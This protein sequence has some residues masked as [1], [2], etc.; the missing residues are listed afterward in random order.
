MK[1]FINNRFTLW[2]LLSI[3]IAF[4]LSSC[5]KFLE[6]PVDGRTAISII[7]DMEK[8]LNSIHP[9][10]DH[11]FTD[12]MTDDYMSKS[13]AGHVVRTVEEQLLPIFSLAI[14]KES[15]PNS[16]FL[17]AGFNPNTAF[18]RYYYN[19]HNATFLLDRTNS[20]VPNNEIDT[21]KIQNIRSKALAIRAYSHFML[22][23]LFG[24]QYNETTSVTDLAMPYIDKYYPEAVV[25]FPRETVK[26]IYDGIESDL[27]TA[28][29]L[30]PQSEENG[31]LEPF[32]FSRKAILA[33][34][35]R[36]YLH[37]KDWDKCL[38]YS[39]ELLVSRS[40]PLNVTG[41][42]TASGNN[43]DKFSLDYFKPD[44]QAYIMMGN[45]TY[46]LI[47]YFF[48]GFYPD[49]IRAFISSYGADPS[50]NLFIQTSPLFNDFIPM[51][52]LYFYSLDKRNMNMPIFTVDEVMFNKAESIIQKNNGPSD[53]SSIILRKLMEAQQMRTPM[54]NTR[55]QEFIESGSANAAILK[56]LDLKRVRFFSE[57]MRW[58]DMRRLGLPLSHKL[59]SGDEIIIDGKNPEDY[60][61]K[62]PQ[63]EISNNI[64]L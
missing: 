36:F 60:V 61:I 17:L 48:H 21:K 4:L 14:T 43:H 46:Q 52:Y 18:R 57:G 19:I 63:E 29:E 45:N 7:S 8:V 30:A 44:N 56:V 50:N 47:G 28:L 3:C 13:I 53:E 41:L 58:F 26:K 20:F 10:S 62:L 49:P 11:H 55:M 2:K 38:K 27:L 23:N 6:E 33:L 12:L 31:L 34:F 16:S 37:K 40:A 24:P 39:N 22:V 25:N 35:S 64:G 59:P 32:S 42:R 15:F 1:V 51:K 9:L 54:I 5:D